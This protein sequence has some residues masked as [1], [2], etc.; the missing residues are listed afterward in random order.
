MVNETFRLKANWKL[1][2]DINLEGYH[3]PFLHKATI[4]GIVLNNGI[5]DTFGLHSRFAV[6]I[7][8]FESPAAL[9]EENW[10]ARLPMVNVQTVLPSTVLLESPLS[11]TMLR[12]YPGQVPGE[13]YITMTEGSWDPLDERSIATARGNHE[14]NK[15][16]LVSE[17][18]PGA[19]A[20]QRGFAS[21]LDTMV[22]GM[23]ESAVS[24]WHNVWDKA[25]AD[26]S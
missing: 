14:T 1:T 26:A 4:H 23:G 5:V 10:P 24:H 6:P 17:D 25:L 22:V 19:E 11:T 7:A 20:C 8:G 13:S 21:G 12:I 2:V 15:R 3:I 9:P 16:V 18:F